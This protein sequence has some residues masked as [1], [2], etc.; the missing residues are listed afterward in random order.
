MKAKFTVV[1][2]LA[3]GLALV[4]ASAQQTVAP[5]QAVPTH[6]SEGSNPRAG[7]PDAERGRAQT[8]GAVPIDSIANDLQRIV[9]LCATEPASKTFE[10]EWA[11]YVSA[12]YRRGVDVDALIDDVL[13]RAE[14]YRA[15][16]AHT[17]QRRAPAAADTTRTRTRMHDTAMA[18]IRKIG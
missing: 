5:R 6:A 8:Q 14:A 10:T 12:H 7:D 4:C 17:A 3:L 16:H 13:R 2:S 18:V 1:P 9:V 11:N 15:S